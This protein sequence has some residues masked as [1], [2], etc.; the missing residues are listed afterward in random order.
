MHKA[1]F[2]QKYPDDLTD[3][4]SHYLLDNYVPITLFVNE[5]LDILYTNGNLED[6]LHIPKNWA[7][8]SI[9]K[10]MDKQT[11]DLFAE[12]ARLA[13]VS[14]EIHHYKDFLF[15]KQSTRLKAD[16]R[17]QQVKVADT[18]EKVVLVEIHGL[19]SSE[20]GTSKKVKVVS[21]DEVT[22]QRILFLENNLAEKERSLQQMTTTLEVTNEELE[23]SNRELIA[24]NEELQSTNEELQSVNE[25]LYTVNTELQL[26]NE[27]V[28]TT[29]NDLNNLLK[30]TNIGTIFLDKELRIRKFTPAVRQHFDL[31]DTD[32]NRSIT[33]FSH[34]I[35]A[36]ELAPICRKVFETLKVFEKEVKDKTGE[37]FLLRILPYR[38]EQAEIKGLVLTFIEIQEVVKARKTAF[39]EAQN[40]K[41]VF[42]NAVATLL[43]IKLDGFILKINKSFA[44]FQMSQLESNNIFDVLPKKIVHKL[45]KALDKVLKT[46]EAVTVKIAIDRK[47]MPIPY[48]YDLNL[49]PIPEE[50]KKPIRQICLSFIDTTENFVQLENLKKAKEK[51]ISFMQNARRQIALIDKDGIIQEVNYTRYSGKTRIELTGTSVYDQLPPEEKASF[52]NSVDAIFAGSSKSEISFKYINKNQEEMDTTLIASPVIVNKKIEFVALIGEPF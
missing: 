9:S 49:T 7:E 12:A 11:A 27:E 31:V 32:I 21:N 33:S 34:Q 38:T 24:N 41:A 50:D 17:F 51:Y 42:Y 36:I 18:T 26:K 47:G 14:E 52:K 25:E 23:S 22:S 43:I 6:I 5:R 19:T 16:L 48:H 4:F 45:K 10:M 40:F 37:V 13:L 1:N 2:S 20:G 15:T 3:P 46:S 29:Y 28:N 44:D 35:E 39:I 30:S 8:M